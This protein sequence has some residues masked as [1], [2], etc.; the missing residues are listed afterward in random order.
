MEKGNWNNNY[1]NLASGLGLC[2]AQYDLLA[3][4]NEY[5]V[6]GYLI[7]KWYTDDYQEKGYVE[8]DSCD[9]L[10]SGLE[11]EEVEKA[12]FWLAINE[13]IDKIWLDDSHSRLAYKVSDWVVEKMVT[14]KLAGISGKAE[15]DW[16]KQENRRLKDEIF[17]LRQENIRREPDT[18]F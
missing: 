15:L 7:D 4:W 9:W 10:G 16:L 11:R 14:R 1:V 17:R 3:T 13:Y 8:A 12:T 6:L 5:F 18:E 2:I